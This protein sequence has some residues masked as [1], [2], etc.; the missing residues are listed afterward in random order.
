[1]VLL[2]GGGEGS[3]RRGLFGTGALLKLGDRVTLPGFERGRWRRLIQGFEPLLPFGFAGAAQRTLVGLGEDMGR[4]DRERAEL[5]AEF[6]AVGEDLLELAFALVGLVRVEHEEGKNL[7]RGLLFEL[8]GGGVLDRGGVGSD[9][10][11]GGD[12]I[13]LKLGLGIKL[14][15]KGAAHDQHDH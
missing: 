13:G 3:D 7:A 12:V 14:T 5:L 1:L 2:A 8:G 6:G 15:A 11:L 4:D 10:R 9:D